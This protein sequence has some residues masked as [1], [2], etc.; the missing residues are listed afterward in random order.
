MPTRRR[1]PSYEPA[2]ARFALPAEHG[3]VLAAEGSPA[4]LAPAFEVA[5][6]IWNGASGSAILPYGHGSAG[7][8]T[9]SLSSAE[10]RP[11]PQRLP[12]A[13]NHHVDPAR[14]RRRAL[15][16]RAGRR[17]RLWPWRL[18]HRW[19]RRI[20]VALRGLRPARG[21]SASLESGPRKLASTIGCVLRSL[22]PRTFRSGLRFD[23]LHGCFS[24][25]GDPV[26]AAP[27]AGGAGGRRTLML[28]EPRPPRPSRT[29]PDRLPA[30]TTRLRRPSAR[31]THFTSGRLV[32]G[33]QAGPEQLKQVLQ[34]LVS[35][36][37]AVV[38]ETPFN[39]VSRR[40]NRAPAEARSGVVGVHI[41]VYPTTPPGSSRDS[42]VQ[43]Q[44][45]V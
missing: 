22:R 29:T 41:R 38:A 39:L 45:F 15:K 42:P 37:R 43:L 8:I 20:E 19:P 24:R 44:R 33:A 9:T 36:T 31:P 2:S 7:R 25:P 10:R 13:S 27:A 5:S 1:L 35:G 32:P 16:R 34:R 28:V 14:R 3:M 17:R 12:P 6:A 18:D 30:C 21:R 4:F 26:R 23:L 40:G 11:L